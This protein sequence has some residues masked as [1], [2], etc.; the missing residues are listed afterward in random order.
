ML[1]KSLGEYRIIREL[2]RGGMGVVYLAEHITLQLK[3]AVKVLPEELSH[4]PDFIARFK[5]EARVMAQLKH[6][7]IV[8]VHYM[9]HDE[10]IYYIVMEYVESP[11]GEPQTLAHVLKGNFKIFQ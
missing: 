7:N 1:G 9:G 5:T 2:G 6:P 10:G 8:Q 4:N 3:Y 11:S